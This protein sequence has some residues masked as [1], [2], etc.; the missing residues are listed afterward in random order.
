MVVGVGL[1]S[2]LLFLW[3]SFGF[4]FFLIISSPEYASWW[5]CS[6]IFSRKCGKCSK[7]VECLYLPEKI[8]LHLQNFHLNGFAVERPK[9]KIY[10]QLKMMHTKQAC[11]FP[12]PTGTEGHSDC[13]SSTTGLHESM[14]SAEFER[15]HRFTKS[16]PINHNITTS[17]E[18][19]MN[20]KMKK[21][22]RKNSPW[23]KMV[24]V[25]NLYLFGFMILIK[26]FSAQYFH[27]FLKIPKTPHVPIIKKI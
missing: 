2:V 25:L 22:E 20:G 5:D 12:L 16:I 13:S 21:N 19:L 26:M 3:K 18:G 23:N 11:K 27:P 4:D 1:N 9:R 24:T 6:S 14:H 10:L 8:Q 17:Y 7:H 15:C